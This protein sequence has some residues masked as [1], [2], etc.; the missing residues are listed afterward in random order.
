MVKSKT[1]L[2]FSIDTIIS[3][4]TYGEEMRPKSSNGVLGYISGELLAGAPKEE[5]SYNPVRL[6]HPGGY[7]LSEDNT[8]PTA[9]VVSQSDPFGETHLVTKQI[10]I[11]II[12][13][14]LHFLVYVLITSRNLYVHYIMY[15]IHSCKTYFWIIIIH[16]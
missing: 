16:L 8:R 13:S 7:L 14:H 2:L 11:V 5:H 4:C 15:L 10:A 1:D 9:S 3:K 12:F 6:P